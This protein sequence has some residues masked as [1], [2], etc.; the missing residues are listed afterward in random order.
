MSKK[1]TEEQYQRIVK[2]YEGANGYVKAIKLVLNYIDELN[3]SGYEEA[4]AIANPRTR[5]LAHDKFVKKEN[6]YYWTSKALDGA[7]NHYQLYRTRDGMLLN[8]FV[9]AKS[10]MYYEKD[11]AY[12][13]AESEIREWG[14][15]PEMFDRVE[16]E[17]E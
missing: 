4:M 5:E 10:K 2:I 13:I 1:F 15:N 6:K 16:V 12:A 9:S 14:Y 7:G 8:I 17:G 11:V 3:W